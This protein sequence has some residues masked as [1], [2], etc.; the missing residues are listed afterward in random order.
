MHS[1]QRLILRQLKGPCQR[2]N[3]AVLAPRSKP[4][5]GKDVVV[6][7]EDVSKALKEVSKMPD[8]K[9]PDIDIGPSVQQ[10]EQHESTFVTEKEPTVL[11]NKM[12]DYIF[13]P[14]SHVL[15]QMESLPV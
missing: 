13:Y 8:T 7:L 2:L 14:I 12:A 15:R 3:K 9:L 11:D 1:R 4:E 10:H 5:A 6:A